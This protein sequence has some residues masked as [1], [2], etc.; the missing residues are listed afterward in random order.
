[1]EEGKSKKAGSENVGSGGLRAPVKGDS[2]S[3]DVLPDQGGATPLGGS[4]GPPVNPNAVP[5]DA[6]LVDESP[7]P[8]GTRL[9]PSQLFPKRT[10]LQ[11]GDVFGGRFE[12]LQVLGEGG[13]GTVY[14]ATD[15]EVD[16]IVALKLIRPEM[17]VHPAIL[18][19]FKQEL[20][21]ARQVTHK[22]VIRIHD[23]S[24]VDGVKFITMEFVE[25]C[26]LRQLLLDKGKLPPEQA[27]EMI[28]QVCLAL[29]AAH[30][31][32]VIHRDLKPQNIMQDKQGR[33][34]VMD[35]GLARSLESDGMTQTGALLGT[36]EYMSPEQALGKQLDARSDLF[37]VGLIFYE[38]L[39][40][41]MPFKADTAVASLLKRNQEQAVPA[42][43][44][45]AS[46]PK[47]LSDIVS[48]CMERDVN[49]RYQSAREILADLDAWQEKRPISAS[50]VKPALTPKRD[51][52]WKWIAVAGLTGAVAIGGWVVS[53]KLISKPATKAAAGP[54]VSLAIL[55]F[56][57]GSGDAGLDWLGPSLADMLSTDV[58][59]SA[60][61]RTISPDHVHQVLSDLQISPSTAIDPTTLARIAEFST[62]DTVVW[63]QYAK[64]GDHIRIDAT[65]R[66][67]KHDR[68]IPVKAEAVNQ[69]AL[70]PAIAQLA[71]TIQQNLSLSTDVLE[72][73]RAKSFQPSSNSL[74]A[75]RNY[76]EG[77]E[78]E[79]QGN[80]LEALKRFEASVQA[81]AGFALAYSKL[82]ETYSNLRNDDKAEQYSRKAV[83]LSDKLPAPER[84]L[85]QANYA[86]VTNDYRKA[87]ESYEN[88]EKVS[89]DDVDVHFHLGVLY[90][91]TG[92]YD[93][94][95][96]EL[97]KVLALDPKHVDALL[98]AGR[99]EIRSKN[100]KGSLDYLNRGLILAVELDNADGKA[101]ILNAIGAAY[102][103]L[104]KPEDALRNYQESLAIK[105]SL[106]QKPG[107]ALTLGNIAQVQAGLGKP[108]E[109]SK[110]YQEAVKLQR[111]IGDKKGLGGTL[112]N[113]GELYRVR[114]RYDEALAAYKE[115][116]QIQR[117]V[118]NEDN[119][120]ICLNNI[121]DVYL[122][123]GQSSD[124]LTYYERA[125]DLRK[126][127]NI[128]SQ[129]GESL[130]NLAEA[131]LKAGDYGQSLDYHLKA[132]ELFRSSGDKNGAAIQSYSM[133]TIFEYQG[134]YGAALKSKEEALKTFRELQDR[135][136]W[137]A[138]ILSGYGNSLSE[139]GRYDEAQKNL[140]EAMSLA[141]E[142]QN[143]TLVAQ[144][145]NFQG[146]T[147][148]YRGDIKAAADLFAQALAASSGEVEKETVLL[149]KLNAAKCAVE[150]KRYQAAL[151]PL[152][153][154]VKE[155]DAA[156]LKYISTEAT[157]ALAEAFLDAHQYPAAR[158]ELETSL[159]T[160]EKLNLQS[161]LARSHFLL[162]RTLEP[163]GSKGAA[164]AAP[165]YATAKRMFEDIRKE[166]GSDLILKRQDLAAIWARPA[167]QP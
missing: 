115:S 40:C 91:S 150:E 141:K 119:Q 132:L 21:T 167:G 45:D 134:R 137:M 2:S 99:V 90:E 79:R 41:K 80:H 128:P 131:S 152:K 6:T 107:I 51:V 8:S 161:L 145:L 88:L 120:A 7:I 109:A 143:K 78:L 25:G 162:G 20:L 65:L 138:E 125:L 101:T 156:G 148:Y 10:E 144:I 86:K 82:G 165:H 37:T 17:A 116:L 33:V 38:L 16:H 32:G 166:S 73:L 44:H 81:D 127:A 67:L 34:L 49:L 83:D 102:R 59:Q 154:V 53:G 103:Q 31:A 39:T 3:S 30:C 19:R 129:V 60:H 42:T 106:G 23:L 97:A 111:E 93:K 100:P 52:P 159:N 27:V 66:D 35:F 113:L 158:R 64:F 63:G 96:V 36:M 43:A 114:S 15:R 47:E 157:L 1:M 56:R 75:L 12:I 18:A 146:D 74:Q 142:L 149:S 147:F 9:R 24:E 110:S 155:A 13:M 124:A 61:L 87:I 62:A 77:L 58:G 98:A 130:H 164:E 29:D 140:T 28:R 89:P 122:A 85:I 160:S 135:S 108:E 46:I 92:A 69:N 104:N 136:F 68:T 126:K 118:G 121:G 55:P 151:A 163:S 105:R 76:H 70:I 139:I 153:A 50:T 72:E 11:A 95:R 57:N 71:Q 112:N 5:P 117:D 123:K 94:A 54:E 22:N 48:K 26:D 4:S 14:K 84:Y 133:G